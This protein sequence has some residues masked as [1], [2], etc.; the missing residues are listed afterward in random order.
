MVASETAVNRWDSSGCRHRPGVSID[1]G[2]IV[3]TGIRLS[4]LREPECPA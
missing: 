4:L 2:V 1:D 3:A